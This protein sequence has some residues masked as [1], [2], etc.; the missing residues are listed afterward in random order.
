[1]SS[2]SYFPVIRRQTWNSS[3]RILDGRASQPRSR[4]C[5]PWMPWT[6]CGQ[7]ADNSKIPKKLLI[8]KKGKNFFLI[9]K[10]P[11]GILEITLVKRAELWN[12]AAKNSRVH[13]RSIYTIRKNSF[14]CLFVFFSFLWSKYP[15][16]DEKRSN[17]RHH[18]VVL[19]SGT[20]IT[21]QRDLLLSLWENYPRKKR[22]KVKQSG[23]RAGEGWMT[24]GESEEP[25]WC[26]TVEPLI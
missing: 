21:T 16:M 15:T 25:C 18:Q 17:H 11:E 26:Q 24:E 7:R 1:M 12:V 13:S 8:R 20:G 9:K 14:F 22:S 4:S 19:N 23:M 3:G 6:W 5:S 2:V 10:C